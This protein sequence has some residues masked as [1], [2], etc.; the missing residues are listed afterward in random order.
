[1]V[2]IL[3]ASICGSVL[4]AIAAPAVPAASHQSCLSA[5]QTSSLN[6]SALTDGLGLT[7]AQVKAARARLSQYGSGRYQ[8]LDGIGLTVAQI[9][10]IQQRLNA[11]AAN[12]HPAGWPCAPFQNRSRVVTWMRAKLISNGFRSA[13]IHFFLVSPR[14]VT[15]NGIQDGYELYGVV[16]KTG[17]RQITV[18]LD[19][20][21][22]GRTYTFALT[23]AA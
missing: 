10:T 23:F 20:P 16:T 8:G 21:G 13:S 1:M 14:Q 11:A 22:W 4:C 15:F 5:T 12:T 6:T 17:T 18:K 2:K 19:R 3:L 9:A 7:A